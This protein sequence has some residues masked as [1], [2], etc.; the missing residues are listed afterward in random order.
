M[1]EGKHTNLSHLD[2]SCFGRQS[3]K[4][5]SPDMRILFDSDFYLANNLDV[6]NSKLDAFAHFLEHGAK[7]GRSPH[8]LFD[9]SYYFDLAP[10]PDEIGDNPL[11]HFLT[12]G[13]RQGFNPHP[14]FDIAFYRQ[15]LDGI[16]EEE[17]PLSH[18]LAYGKKLRLSPPSVV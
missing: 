13:H 14:L 8:P 10:Q 18:F 1:N 12:R 6:K 7:E 11:L 15:Q 3:M 16:L 17:N 9:S 4:V 5:L 2:E